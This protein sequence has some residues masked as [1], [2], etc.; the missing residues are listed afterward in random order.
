MPEIWVVGAGIAGA[1][2]AR[3]LVAAGITPVVVDRGRRAGG[4]LGLRRLNS[5]HV[6]DVGASYFTVSHPAFAHLVTTLTETGD[7]R[8]WTDT[9][10]VADSTGILGTKTGPMRYASPAGLR[11]IV[12]TLFDGIEVRSETTLTELP[13]SADAIALCMPGPQAQRLWPDA[14]DQHWEPVIAVTMVFAQRCWRELDG[15]FVNDDP[16]ITWIADDGKRRGDDA[17]VLVAHVDPV[18]SARH[19]DDPEDL[20]GPVVATVLRILGITEYPDEVLT[21][22]WTFA[23]PITGSDEPFFIAGNVGIAGDAYFSGPRVEAAWLSGNALGE[24]LAA[25]FV[26]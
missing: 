18:A 21:Q 1:A 15:V 11:S 20:V 26:R 13:S 2:C 9:F 25:R 5:G 12:D 24:E 19:L 4:R 3:T 8:E 23:K 6:V 14:P 7:V 17:P 16:L 10:H 22:R